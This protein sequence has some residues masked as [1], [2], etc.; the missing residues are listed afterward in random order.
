[1]SPLD[2]H[3]TGRNRVYTLTSASEGGEGW[4]QEYWGHQSA[5][6]VGE[7]HILNVVGCLIGDGLTLTVETVEEETNHE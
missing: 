3:I 5:G 6:E 7:S 1:M 2:I 4:L